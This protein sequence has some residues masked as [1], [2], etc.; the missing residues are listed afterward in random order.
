MIKRQ[1][2]PLLLIVTVILF[3]L[4][5]YLKQKEKKEISSFK[6]ELKMK[7]TGPEYNGRKIIGLTPGKE[8]E[9]FE[10]LKINNV[11]SEDWKTEFK[12]GLAAQGGS[13]VKDME[14][15][16]LDSF[17]WSQD[18]VALNVESVQVT[19]SNEK[20]ESTKFRALV[21]SSSGKILQTWDRPVIDSVN[22]REGHGLK[23]DP[24]YHND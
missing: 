22:P 7:E 3:G 14:I 4:A 23:I 12:K 8:I 5:F 15:N 13:S 1:L 6:Q 20:G 17:I 10:T 24:R 9:E 11:V 21:D 18:G 2:L 19:L 16:L